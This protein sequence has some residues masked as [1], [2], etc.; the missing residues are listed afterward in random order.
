MREPMQG[1]GDSAMNA[2]LGPSSVVEG[3]LSFE[4]PLRIDGS[5]T[6][7]INTPDRLIIGEAAKVSATISCG[8]V[9]VSG[10]VSGNIRATESIEL[11]D[12]ARVK[13]DL[14]T[15]SLVIDKGVVFDGGC[16][17]LNGAAAAEP[18]SFKEA[19]RRGWQPQRAKPHDAEA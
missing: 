14:A 3:K 18:A 1:V 2:M 8:S 5:F 10:E 7:E 4:G 12:R 15:P 6:G 11:R 17:M 16:H 9:V 13:A 19:R